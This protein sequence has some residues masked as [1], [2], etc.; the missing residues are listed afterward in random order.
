MFESGGKDSVFYDTMQGFC[1][2]SCLGGKCRVQRHFR[3]IEGLFWL[4]QKQGGCFNFI[5]LYGFCPGFERSHA[6]S[7]NA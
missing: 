1:V 5:L 3:R 2:S 4:F 6:V 7:R